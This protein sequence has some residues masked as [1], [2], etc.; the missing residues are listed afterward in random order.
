MDGELIEYQVLGGGAE[1]RSNYKEEFFADANGI[2]S[3]DNECPGNYSNALGDPYATFM[4]L[5]SFKNAD[6]EYSELRG[7]RARSRNA[8]G[9]NVKGNRQN[10]IDYTPLGWIK[11]GVD[12]ATSPERVAAREERRRMRA[13]R[14]NIR[15]QSK[16]DARVSKA[17]AKQTS[18][19]AQRTA[20]ESL[21]KDSQADVELARAIATSPVQQ[22]KGLSTGAI[23]GIT[24]GGLAVVGL[25]TYFV[26]KSKNKGK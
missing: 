17:G 9:R 3:A 10:W 19:E 4:N 7:R 21:G 12:T 8:R 1:L 14:K 25:I 23:V 22:K 20:A 2:S 15:T 16:A 5:P 13:E 11:K 18:A 6:G 24:L 26:I